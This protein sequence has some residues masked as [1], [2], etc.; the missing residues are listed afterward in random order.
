MHVAI[1]VAVFEIVGLPVGPIVPVS[2]FAIGGIVV[3]RVHFTH[4]GRIAQPLRA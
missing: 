1:V 4:L 3:H 2:R